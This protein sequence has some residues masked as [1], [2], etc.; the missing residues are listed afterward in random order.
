MPAAGQFVEAVEAAG[1]AGQAAGAPVDGLEVGQR[2]LEH[3][4]H[5]RGRLAQVRLGD[6]E[7]VA[8]GL[9]EQLEGVGAGVVALPDQ[10]CH[11]LDH[12]T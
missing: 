10:E 6:A 4:V 8:L 12:L 11:R 2:V 5:R 1:H 3:L 9:I 7:D